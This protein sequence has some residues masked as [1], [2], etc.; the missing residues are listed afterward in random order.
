MILL[1]TISRLKE[2]YK[3]RLCTVG[4]PCKCLPYVVLACCAG[5]SGAVEVADGEMASTWSSFIA[6]QAGGGLASGE[7]SLLRCRL[8]QTTNRGAAQL[9]VSGLGAPALELIDCELDATE[10]PEGS[11]AMI[12]KGAV[13]AFRRTEFHGAQLSGVCSVDTTT[14]KVLWGTG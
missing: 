13:P 2:V 6:G 9:L 14:L 5:G 4:R 11:C 8:A 1:D 7:L 10:T 3:T 12:E